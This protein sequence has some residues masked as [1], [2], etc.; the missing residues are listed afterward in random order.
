M[1]GIIIPAKTVHFLRWLMKGKKCPVQVEIMAVEGR[2]KFSFD[3]MHITSKT[4]DGTYPDYHRVIP[5]GNNQYA[6]VNS[7]QLL[8]DIKSVTIISSE[9]G[10]AVRCAFADNRLTM[11]VNNPDS[12]ISFIELP[13]AYECGDMDIGFN[14]KHFSEIIAQACP[15]GKDVTIRLA[16]CGSPTLFTGSQAGWVGVLMPMRV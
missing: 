13:C 7:V 6:A 11:S 16:D 12:G 5:T 3:G 4:I 9:R 10:R 8:K 2:V 1:S 14:A 15:D